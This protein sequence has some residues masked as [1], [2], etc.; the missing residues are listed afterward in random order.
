MPTDPLYAAL[1]KERYASSWWV[2]PRPE[3]EDSTF[4]Q[5]VRR[6]V[7]AEVPEDAHETEEALW[8]S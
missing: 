8:V 7:L 3:V 1:M 5:G 6:R 4:I 2:T